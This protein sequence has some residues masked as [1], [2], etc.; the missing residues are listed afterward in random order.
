M[1]AP[2]RQIQ[3]LVELA[4]K[5]T[6]ASGHHR[7][8]SFTHVTPRRGSERGGAMLLLGLCDSRGRLSD[9]IILRLFAGPR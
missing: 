5:L 1:R 4:A 2:A 7:A 6:A 9:G 3:G 8:G